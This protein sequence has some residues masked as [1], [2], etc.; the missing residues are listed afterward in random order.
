M[1][2]WAS[3]TGCS[4][5]SPAAGGRGTEEFSHESLL[6]AGMLGVP[7]RFAGVMDA[8]MLDLPTINLLEQPGQIPCDVTLWW[9]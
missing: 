8:L 5:C 4:I 7:A 1:H 2:G 6:H 3:A 9:R